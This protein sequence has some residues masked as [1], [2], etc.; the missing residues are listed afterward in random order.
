MTI[1]LPKT[2]KIQ[3]VAEGCS[4]P[5]KTAKTAVDNGNSPTKTIA[6]ADEKVCKPSAVNNGKPITTPKATMVKDFNCV[7]FGTF[8]LSKIRQNRLSRPAMN[9]RTTVKNS[10]LKPM[11]AIRVAGKDPAKITTPIKP[12]SQA[13][14]D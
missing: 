4:P 13:K 1:L 8:C 2:A 11:T 12:F 14:F 5:R 6:C 9:A 7:R 3:N 10:G